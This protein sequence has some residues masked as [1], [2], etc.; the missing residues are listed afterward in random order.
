MK[1]KRSK[2]K[3]IP[4]DLGAVFVSKE[5]ALW[6]RFRDARKVALDSLKESEIIETALVELAERKIAEIKDLD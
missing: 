2:S 6:I 1:F 3:D 4:D 5:E